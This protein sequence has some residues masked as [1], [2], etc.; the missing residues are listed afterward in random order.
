M[1]T[2]DL[3]GQESLRLLLGVQQCPHA[4]TSVSELA[5]GELSRRLKSNP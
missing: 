1:G 5:L 3:Q 4:W 2:L